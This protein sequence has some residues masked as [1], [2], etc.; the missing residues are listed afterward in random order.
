MPI[1]H[2]ILILIVLLIIIISLV[3]RIKVGVGKWSKYVEAKAQKW[4]QESRHQ[5]TWNSEFIQPAPPG[6]TIHDIILNICQLPSAI[7]HEARLDIS[8]AT[9]EAPSKDKGSNESAGTGVV[10]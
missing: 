3:I 5:P 10:C 7:D 2:H 1:N 6:L 8:E 9:S 4:H